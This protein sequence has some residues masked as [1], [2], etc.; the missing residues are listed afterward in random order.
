M[1]KIKFVFGLFL[2]FILS[3]SLSNNSFR[4]ADLT[5]FLPAQ[6]SDFS[7]ED[8]PDV[9]PADSIYDFLG[10]AATEYINYGVLQAANSEYHSS[11]A[12]YSVNIF[13]FAGSLG[14]FGI[15]ARKRQPD[16]RFISIGAESLIGNGYLYYFK[17]KFFMTINSVGNKL[18]DL[19]QLDSF[20]SAIDSL[21]PGSKIFPRQLSVFPDRRLIAHSEQFWP[22]GFISYEVPDSCFSA[23][24]M[25]KGETC[26][27]FY[28]ADRPL[29]QFETFK[30]LIQIKGRILTHMAGV[31]DNSIYAITDD[32]GKILAG[33]SDGI[34]YGVM[35]VANDYWAK[36]LCEELFEN[37]GKKL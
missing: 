30:K 10:D 4:K 34:I 37:L 32:D 22:H 11:N 28:A 21:I 5:K 12:T 20:A 33:F 19:Q 6:I 16:D 17:G 18:P 1:K 24:Y 36:A 23:D 13:E 26:R 2:L 35:N 31:G 7:R 9:F 8:Q 15:Y 27:L 29:S 25:R 14:A 3:C